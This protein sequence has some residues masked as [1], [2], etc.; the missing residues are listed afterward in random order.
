[1]GGVE[2]SLSHLKND[3]EYPASAETIMAACN[4]MSDVPADDKEFFANNLPAGTYS[5]PDQVINAV[6]EKI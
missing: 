4:N 5:G 1:M 2:A 3:V 6:L